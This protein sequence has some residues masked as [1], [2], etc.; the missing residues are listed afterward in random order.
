MNDSIYRYMKVGIIYSMAFPAVAKGEGPVVETIRKLLCDDYFTAIEIT[1]IKDGETRRAVRKLLDTS[2][3]T[4]T[5]GAQPLLLTT[6]SNINDLDESRR[7]KA[8]ELLKAGIDEAYEMGAEAFTVLSGRYEPDKKEEA[9]AQLLMSVRELCAYAKARGGMKVLL[10]AFDYN[11]D[12]KSLIGPALLAKR[13]AGDIR[14]DFDNFGVTVDL[15][16]I[17]LIHESIG[18]AVL[19]VREFLTHVHIGNCVV[20]DAALPGFGDLHPR[21]GF[22]G[23]ENGVEQL[24]MFLKL[25]LEIGFLNEK[26]PPVMNF[27]VKP[28]G[29]E[30]PAVT[31]A[32]SKRALT[33]AWAKL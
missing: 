22:P 8:L 32:N 5:F 23:G 17:P 15:S 18:E 26:N 29:D 30:D 24:A 25:L 13:F 2:G 12:K 6:G 14:K 33:L 21:F 11:V 19:P 4:V 3:Q 31:I 27:E 7:Q 28:F 16:H 20:K 10:E 1:W 9:Y